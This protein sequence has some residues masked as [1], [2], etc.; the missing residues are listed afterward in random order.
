[1][2]TEPKPTVKLILQI[3]SVKKK[4]ETL[5]PESYDKDITIDSAES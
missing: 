4:P 2:I 5:S 3:H 1:M